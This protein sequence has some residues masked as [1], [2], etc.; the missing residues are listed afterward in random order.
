MLHLNSITNLELKTPPTIAPV[1]EV[2]SFGLCCYGPIFHFTEQP[3]TSIRSGRRP[4][5]EVNLSAFVYVWF[6]F[7][8]ALFYSDLFSKGLPE[9]YVFV[10]TFRM[11]ENSPQKPWSLMK[12]ADSNGHDQFNVQINPKQVSFYM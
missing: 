3:I 4:H 6:L 11:N 10:A 12:I 2:R 5:M 7:P 9:Q 1:Y 8:F